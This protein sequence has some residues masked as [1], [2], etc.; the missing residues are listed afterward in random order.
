VL[1]R[2]M[3]DILSAAR[4]QGWVMEP[5]AKRL[6]SLAGIEVPGFKW[7]TDVKEATRFAGD[8]GYPVVAKVVSPALIHKSDKGGVVPGIE[9][10]DQLR[11][12]FS[13]FSL[14]DRFAGM[15][16]EEMI[17]GI[18][19]IIG[20]KMDYQFGPVVLLG[21]GGTE[22]EIYRD[23]TLRMAPLTAQDVT[24]MVMRL[25]ARPLLEGYRGSKPIDLQ[26]LSQTVI[27]FSN[28]LMDLEGHIESIDLNPVMCSSESCVVAD[29]RIMLPA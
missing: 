13:R 6:L 3:Q 11:D 21:I 28:L 19:L 12:T 24:S 23:A 14:M 25:K 10:K 20:G 9:N 18:E 15:L 2:E 16:V 4:V 22:A 26:K 1:S 8:I 5:E 29:A 7:A 27:T 17:E